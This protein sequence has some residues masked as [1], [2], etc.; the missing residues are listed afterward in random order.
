M[1]SSIVARLIAFAASA[2]VTLTIVVVLADYGLPQDD[3]VQM[4]AV[5][6]NAMPK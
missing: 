6:A 3:G 4:Y 1:H 2:A 5:A